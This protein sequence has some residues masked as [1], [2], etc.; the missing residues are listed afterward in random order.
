M[1]RII[2]A[3]GSPRRK[4]LLSLM[5]VT[6]EVM[7][8][9]KEEKLQDVEPSGLVME[10]AKMKACDIAQQV[11][12]PAVIIGADT[13]VAC[14]NKVLG[15]PKDTEDARQMITMLAGNSHE[16]YT[17]VTMVIKEANQTERMVTFY[18]ATKVYVTPMSEEEIR[19]YVATGEPMDK[20]GSY[21]IQGVFAPYISKIEGDY[22]NIV[23]FP[24]SHLYHA[25]KDAG[26]DLRTGM[27]CSTKECTEQAEHE[28]TEKLDEDLEAFLD[29]TTYMEKI[30]VLERIRRNLNEYRMSSIEISLDLPVG[31][32]DLER[33]YQIVIDNLE[34]RMRFECGRLR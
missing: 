29:A 4:E 18:E 27:C 10:L 1:Y 8:S 7:V 12:G 33:R 6:Y 19:S 11:K 2:L 13:V 30:K 31:E 22:Y 5:G 9:Q 20:A 16:V 17:G 34:T 32:N 25:A 28:V 23:G 15:K 26:I 24:I 3:S 14:K 21:A